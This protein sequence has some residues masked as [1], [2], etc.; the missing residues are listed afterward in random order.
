MKS[1]IKNF[2]TKWITY[3]PLPTVVVDYDFRIMISNDIA[4][5]LCDF[6]FKKPQ[7]L[8]NY[9]D[10]SL[11]TYFIEFKNIYFRTPA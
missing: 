9:F 8:E 11:L 7:Y 2:F 4:T 10:K 6:N 5:L 3:F 1:E